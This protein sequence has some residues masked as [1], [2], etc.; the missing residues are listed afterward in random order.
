M[1]FQHFLTTCHPFGTF[2]KQ[3]KNA[4]KS[5]FWSAILDCVEWNHWNEIIASQGFIL[6]LPLMLCTASASL[7][8]HGAIASGYGIYCRNVN[9]S[10]RQFKYE[11]EERKRCVHSSQRGW[12]SFV[13]GFSLSVD[14]RNYEHDAWQVQAVADWSHENNINSPITCCSDTIFL[15]WT[16]RKNFAR[17][18]MSSGILAR[19][20][21][22][23]KNEYRSPV[24][25]STGVL[26]TNF[27]IINS[28]QEFSRKCRMRR[29][30]FLSIFHRILKGELH[31]RPPTSH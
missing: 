16:G 20:T 24:Q 14:S 19:L 3:S 17:A 4:V 13:P 28:F 9:S 15:D 7:K 25:Y 5:S 22:W 27:Y 11:D 6:P 2:R 29:A 31:I 23:R 21:T 1:S 30:I 18:S 8:T 10:K 12:F 26:Q